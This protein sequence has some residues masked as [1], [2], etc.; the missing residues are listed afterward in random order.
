MLLDAAG[1]LLL[2]AEP[3]ADTYARHARAHG[4]A[5]D[6]ADIRVRLREVMAAATHLR[7]GAPDWRPY[8]ERVVF[9]ATACD[10]P[11]LVDGLIDHFRRADAWQLTRGALRCCARVRDAG[12][13][14]AIV[15]NW[16]HNLR[17]LLIDLGVDAIVDAI[18]VSAEEQIE[19]PDPRIFERA[20]ARLGVEASAAVHVGDS[21]EHDVAG[22]R[23]AG[24]VALHF[25]HDVANFDALADWIRSPSP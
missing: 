22:A 25:G 16:D 23:A 17:P 18:V 10:D 6:A 2:P 14:I 4:R 5:I 20:C 11:K 7:H 15:S 13:A 12:L 21:L 9:E 24:C 19:K 3:V 8:W 1:T